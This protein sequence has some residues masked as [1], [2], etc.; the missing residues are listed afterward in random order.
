MGTNSLTT[1]ASGDVITASFFNDFNTALGGD[2]IGRN[3]SGVPAAGQNLGTVALPWG[4]IRCNSIIVNGTTINQSLVAVPQNVVISGKKR[5]TSNQPAYIT[6]NGAAL[7]FIVAGLTTNLVVDINGTNVSVVA[8][9]TKSGL[10][11][12]PSTNNTA[13]VNDSAAVDQHDT[14]LWGEPEH[15]KYITIDNIGSEITALNGKYAAFSITN[16]SDTE[17][18]L[19]RVNTTS[20]RL[21]NIKRGYFFNSALAPV[22]RIFFSDN[23]VI[24]LL[25]AGWIFITNDGTTVDVT[26]TQPVWS[27]ESPSGPATGDYWYDLANNT[28]KRYDGAS[29]QIISRTYIGAFANTTT[30]CVGARCVDFFAQYK[31]DNTMDLEVSTTEIVRAFDEYQRVN[32]AGNNIEFKESR[33]TWN[34][35]TDL[36]GSSDMYSATEQASRLYYLYIKDTGDTVISDISPYYRKDLLGQ[37]HPHNPWRCVGAAYNNASSNIIAAGARG[38][39][40]RNDL[41]LSDGNGHGAVS[42][43]IRRFTNVIKRLG[44]AVLYD[45]SDDEANLGA[46]FLV[47]EPF[48]GVA[49]YGDAGA[50]A[51][52]NGLSLNST[53]LT[54]SVTAITAADI[55]S[56]AA[57]GGS[58][59]AFSSVP[60]DFKIGDIIRPHDDGNSNGS[61]LEKFH[62]VKLRCSAVE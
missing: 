32:V 51:S 37:Y 46:E 34:I 13:L 52:N 3:T 26:Y 2:F 50:A 49:A 36:A 61:D 18:F 7:S 17:Y 20:N 28:W 48:S 6:P 56:Y 24:T 39:C 30:A 19:A 21:E 27:F 53:Q 5:S 41:F 47:T 55:L 23:D 59:S 12:A 38:P 40:A 33:P 58:L 4:V 62:I 43:K 29:F 10:T 60:K 1:R 54:T 45:A 8:D 16:G 42:T 15:R 11:A 31:N 35:T 44:T 22:N 14:R 25:K 9:L 57:N